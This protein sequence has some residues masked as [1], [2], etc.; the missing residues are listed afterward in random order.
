MQIKFVNLSENLNTA[1]RTL[2]N[3]AIIKSRSRHENIRSVWN[4]DEH[5]KHSSDVSKL[6]KYFY[7]NSTWSRAGTDL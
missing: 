2:C 5:K 6:M 7:K 3:D 1:K 4:A